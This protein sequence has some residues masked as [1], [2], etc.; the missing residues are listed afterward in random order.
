MISEVAANGIAIDLTLIEYRLLTELVNHIGTPVPPTDL[1]E[2]VWGPNYETEN[3][4]K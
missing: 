2:R 3:L 4:I 1:L